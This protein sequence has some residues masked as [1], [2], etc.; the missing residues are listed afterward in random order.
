MLILFCDFID[1]NEEIILHHN[2]RKRT[3]DSTESDFLSMMKFEEKETKRKV[4][5]VF[6]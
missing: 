3:I 5:L 4:P 1:D 6:E 2:S